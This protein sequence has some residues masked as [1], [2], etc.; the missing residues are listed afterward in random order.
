[1]GQ[2]APVLESVL[3]GTDMGAVSEM[4]PVGP[5]RRRVEPREV[6]PDPY[7]APDPPRPEPFVV[8]GDRIGNI[9][10]SAPT[11]DVSL[12]EAEAVMRGVPMA[13]PATQYPHFPVAPA[14]VPF[15]QTVAPQM[16]QNALQQMVA[17]A[18]AAALQQQ[19]PPPPMPTPAAAPLPFVGPNVAYPNGAMRV[20]P[21]GPFMPGRR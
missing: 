1:M 20:N 10:L 5:Q 18:V 11:R 17:Q 13:P 6:P 4:P 19:Q 21:F 14:Q 12:A 2:A 3:Y 9:D 8:Q 16:D 7:R 15:A